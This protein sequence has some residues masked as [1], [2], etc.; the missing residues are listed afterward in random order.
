M[1]CC[2]ALLDGM[3]IVGRIKCCDEDSTV[4]GSYTC[5][6]IARIML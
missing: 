1:M 5:V 4:V 3:R 6:R 2:N